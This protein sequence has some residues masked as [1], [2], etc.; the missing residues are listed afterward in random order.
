M[1]AD[2]SYSVLNPAADCQPVEIAE[3]RSLPSDLA[4]LFKRRAEQLITL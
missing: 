3:Q 4:A 1:E 2:E